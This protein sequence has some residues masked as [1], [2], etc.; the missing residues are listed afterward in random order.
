MKVLI[1]NASPKRRGGA[2]KFFSTLLRP[3]LLGCQ[4]QT[5]PLHGQGDYA[6]AVGALSWAESV[7]ISAPLYVDGAPSHVLQ[8]LEQAETVCQAKKLDFKL[9]ALSNNGFVEG[10]QNEP[11]L[12]IYEGW[13]QRSGAVWGGGLGIGGGVM[14]NWLCMLFPLFALLHTVEVVMMAQSGTLT[15]LAA[16]DCYSGSL[17]DLFFCAGLFWGLG[18][19]GR[20]IRKGI[21]G[22]NRYTRVLVPSFIFLIGADIF[23]LLSAL[24]HG[25]LPHKLFRKDELR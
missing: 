22:L 9:Y 17:M 11:H 20:R 8:F 23:M 16:L 24:F 13:C 12:R 1:L 14:L 4:I 7:V 10:R 21:C 6:A 18:L 5:L 25:T 15:A 2:S 19:M 3:F